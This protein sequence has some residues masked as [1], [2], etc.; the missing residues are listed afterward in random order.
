M[1]ERHR[2]SRQLQNNHFAGYIPM[3]LSLIQIFIEFLQYARYSSVHQT[4][5][6]EQ[7]S[8]SF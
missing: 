1:L 6:N 4:Y 3:Y 5:G 7:G 2:D 8:H